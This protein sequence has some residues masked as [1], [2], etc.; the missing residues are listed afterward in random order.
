MGDLLARADGSDRHNLTRNAVNDWGPAW[1]PDGTKIAYCSGL[2]N[3][4]EIHVMNAVAIADAADLHGPPAVK[5][6]ARVAGDALG[7]RE[8]ITRRDFLNTATLATGAALMGPLAPRDLL[9]GAAEDFDGYGGVGDYRHANGNTWEVMEAAHALRD[10][11]FETLPRDDVDTGEA[12]DLV[13]VGGASAAWRRRW[14]FEKQGTG[15]AVPGDGQPRDLRRRGPAERVPGGRA[16]PRRTPGLGS[17]RCRTA[18]GSS[19]GTT[20]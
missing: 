12:F 1:S 15:R 19:R 4:Y 16:A 20:S 14:L 17:F 10:R 18:A 6:T 11:R 3:K 2:E 5:R 9:A 7:M 13:V 8:R